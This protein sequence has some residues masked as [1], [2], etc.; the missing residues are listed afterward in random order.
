MEIRHSSEFYGPHTK[1]F[2]YVSMIPS[3]DIPL[4]T[5]DDDILYPKHWLRD[6]ANRAASD[7]D[8]IF[9]YR[10]HRIV[11]D[12]DRLAPYNEWSSVRDTNASITNFATGVMG[13][14][15]PPKFLDALRNSGDAFKSSALFADDVWLNSIASKN[16]IPVAQV[17]PLSA[18]FPTEVGTQQV[19]LHHHNVADLAN[20]EYLANTYDAR[21]I[22]LLVEANLTERPS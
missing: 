4:V 19:A 12:G 3:H 21:T 2:P 18:G 10:A 14:L 20:D 15:Y 22:G 7:R 13:A 5:A 11:L 16:G 17:N 1:Y 9:C 6:L 8:T